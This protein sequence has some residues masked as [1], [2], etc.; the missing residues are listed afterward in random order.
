MNQSLA[1]AAFTACSGSFGF[2]WGSV[3]IFDLDSDKQT[4]QVA[5]MFSA[6]TF[7]A[8]LLSLDIV[9]LERVYATF[10]PFRH[11][12]TKLNTYIVVFA[13]TWCLALLVSFLRVYTTYPELYYV[14]V[15][16]WT[17][18]LMTP[19]II[20]ISYTAIF[21]KVVMTKNGL[22]QNQQQSA[23]QR[24]Q[25]RERELAGT[26]F[27]MSVLSL[28]TCLPYNIFRII[29]IHKSR[30]EVYDEF[31]STFSS[32]LFIQFTNMLINPIV[33]LFRIRNFRKAFFKFVF[34]CSRHRPS[35]HPLNNNNNIPRQPVP[36][37]IELGHT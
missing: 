7:L 2:F 14:L 12:T 36:A 24:Q 31:P 30:F 18:L 26:L 16:Y 19:F 15:C 33:Y 10:L 35:I 13:C 3:K 9:G 28:I 27:M 21:I 32:V 25:K 4:L 11:R 29:Y 17:I 34:K 23:L 8:S 5:L 20:L 6:F 22:Q 37:V 1:D